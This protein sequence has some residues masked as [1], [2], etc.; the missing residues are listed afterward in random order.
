[1]AEIIR[2]NRA[3]KAGS[4]RVGCAAVILDPA[5]QRV[6]L[7]RRADNS[8]WCLPGGGMEPGES[9]TEACIRE[10]F[11]E[12]GLVVAVTRL[13]GVYSDPDRLMVYA[14]GNAYHVVGLCFLAEHRGGDPVLSEETTQFGFFSLEEI[15][16]LPMLDQHRERIED[17]FADRASAV[18]R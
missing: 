5:R 11:E 3:A 9:V 1:M 15:D 8:L 6:F 17:A 7:T 4:V 16:S 12:T 13:I 2:G 14:D 10:V 18:I